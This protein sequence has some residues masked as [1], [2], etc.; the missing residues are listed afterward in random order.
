MEFAVNAPP[1]AEVNSSSSS[2]SI[3]ER[4]GVPEKVTELAGRIL[5]AVLFLLSGF[6]KLAA[7]G[8]TAAYMSSVGVPGRLLPVVIATEVVGALAIIVG[9][10]TRTVAVLLA[11]FSLLTAITFHRNF[12]DQMQMISFLKDVSIAGG[13]LLLV[14]NGAGALSIDRHLAK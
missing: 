9:W 3:K 14:A 4:K 13:F 5:L 12:A 2:D 6:G 11:G 1:V 10:K 8:A 7:Y